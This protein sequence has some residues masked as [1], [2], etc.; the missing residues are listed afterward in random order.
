MTALFEDEVSVPH[1]TA[2][3]SSRQRTQLQYGV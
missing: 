1:E 3:F 2:R